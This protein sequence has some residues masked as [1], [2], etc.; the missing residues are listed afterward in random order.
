MR[1]APARLRFP[2][3]PERLAAI[4]EERRTTPFYYGG[5]DCGL[6]AADV[7][8]ALTGSDPAAAVRGLY[9]NEDALERLVAE[10][11]GFEAAVAQGLAEYGAPECPKAFAMRGD[12]A[13]VDAGNQLMLGVVL[14]DTVAVTG[15]DGLRFIPLRLVVRTWAI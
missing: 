1:T 11:G 5:Q 15:L 9:D 3:W 8:V 12:V 7:A 13:L 4:V 10:R 6:F 2:D 14:G